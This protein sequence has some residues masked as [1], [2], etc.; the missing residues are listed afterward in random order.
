MI[1]ELKLISEIF[2]TATE[3][4]LWAYLAF[5]FYKLAYLSLIVFPILSAVKFIANKVFIDEN[6]KN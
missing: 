6:S 3:N 2:K 4:A 5:I 1:E